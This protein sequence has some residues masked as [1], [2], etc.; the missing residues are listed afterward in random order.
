MKPP[1]NKPATRPDTPPAPPVPADVI[2]SVTGVNIKVLGEA[3]AM[4]LAML[5]QTIGS[6]ADLEFE[7]AVRIRDALKDA[8][9]EQMREIIEDILYAATQSGRP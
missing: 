6:V 1:R 9:P 3:P 4:A 5:Y 8:T 7:E 2:D